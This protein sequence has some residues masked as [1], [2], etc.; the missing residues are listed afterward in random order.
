MYMHFEAW[1]LVKEEGNSDTISSHTYMCITLHVYGR[2]TIQHEYTYSIAYKHI[3]MY[4][5][6]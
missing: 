2:T 5:H 3:Y 6:N 1:V 4:V